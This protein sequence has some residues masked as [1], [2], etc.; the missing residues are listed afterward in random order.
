[1]PFSATFQRSKNYDVAKYRILELF[2]VKYAGKWFDM[3]VKYLS[4]QL[5]WYMDAHSKNS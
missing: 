2:V 5:T 1:M 4:L 3:Q